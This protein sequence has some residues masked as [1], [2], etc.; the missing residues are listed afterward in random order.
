MTTEQRSACRTFAVVA[1]IQAVAWAV[2]L[3]LGN[4]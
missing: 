3:A 4:P 1:A 2:A